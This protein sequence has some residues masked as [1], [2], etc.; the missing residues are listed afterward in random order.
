MFRSLC[1]VFLGLWLISVAQDIVVWISPDIIGPVRKARFDVN[2]ERSFYTWLSSCTLFVAGILSFLQTELH[3]DDRKMRVYWSALGVIF[4]LLSADEAMSFHEKLGQFVP[5]SHNAGLL[6]YAWV[7]PGMAFV[8]VVGLSFVR[9]L[10][11]LPA[12]ERLLLILS[13]AIFVSGAIGMEMIAGNL[14]DNGMLD[15]FTYRIASNSEEALEVLGV[16]LFVRVLLTRLQ[17]RAAGQDG[18]RTSMNFRATA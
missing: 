4:I 17:R 2:S 11:N 13:G 16:L 5:H 14:E 6:T 18:Q 12:H 3:R 8:L 7:I 9:F 10:L 15:T 1:F